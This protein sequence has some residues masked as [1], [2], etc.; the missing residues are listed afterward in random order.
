MLGRIRPGVDRILELL[1]AAA[2]R[3]A[4]VL[5]LAATLSRRLG[6][7]GAVADLGHLGAELTGQVVSAAVEADETTAGSLPAYAGTRRRLADRVDLS[8]RR[9]ADWA[10]D[11]Q[12]L[13]SEAQIAFR[14]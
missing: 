8:V 7:V 14:S 9:T 1:R 11:L 12:R 4:P 10:A 3:T 2:S 6:A 5:T 13:V